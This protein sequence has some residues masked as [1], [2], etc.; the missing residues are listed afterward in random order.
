[1][2]GTSSFLFINSHLAAGDQNLQ[3]RNAD[4]HRINSSMTLYSR[5]KGT[6][7]SFSPLNLKAD[8]GL[9]VERFD[10]VFWFGDLNYRVNFKKKRFALEELIENKSFDVLLAHDQLRKQIKEKKAFDGFTEGEINFKPT[11]KFDEE[12]DTYDTSTKGNHLSFPFI[13]LARIPS[14]TDRILFLP[15]ENL[16]ILSYNCCSE[17]WYSDH[18][19]VNAAFKVKYQS[20]NFLASQSSRSDS[21]NLETAAC[22]LL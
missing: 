19:P 16:E 15:H 3:A 5:S 7:N 21:Q 6:M 9:V 2:V 11:Y 20:N 8:R 10:Y 18:R 17:I 13:L 4:F 14:Y 1:M 22:T 12:A